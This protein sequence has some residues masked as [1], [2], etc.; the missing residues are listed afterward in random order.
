MPGGSD[1]RPCTRN[2]PCRTFDGALAKTD[3]GG[4]IVALETG[5]YDPTTVTKSI[6]LS[7]APG[8]DGFDPRRHRK[9]SDHPWIENS[10]RRQNE[11]HQGFHID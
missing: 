5:S 9:C 2:Q 11:R 6:T 7:S 4:E 1:N 8:A 10:E 3:P